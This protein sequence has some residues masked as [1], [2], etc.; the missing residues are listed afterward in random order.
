MITHSQLEHPNIVPL[1]GVFC[2]SPDTP[3]L[4]VLPLVERGCL[5][6]MIA[7]E[8]IHGAEFARIVC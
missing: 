7:D 2:E 5:A 3:P 1:L 6:N 8:V 4:M